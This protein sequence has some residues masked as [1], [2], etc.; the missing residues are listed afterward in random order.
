MYI[1]VCKAV[2]DS[3]IRRLVADGASSL[4]E[5]ARDTGLGS[6]CGKCVPAAREVLGEALQQT[7]QSRPLRLSELPAACAA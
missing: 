3:R 4:R 5:V 2:S 1:C 6:C 7:A